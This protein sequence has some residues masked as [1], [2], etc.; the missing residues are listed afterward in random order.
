[1]ALDNKNKNINNIKE[2]NEVKDNNHYSEIN[3]MINNE[4]IDKLVKKIKNKY[5]QINEFD[6]EKIEEIIC[7]CIGDFKT[8]CTF[9][10]K[11]V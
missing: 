6:N 3:I 10:E 5:K 8:I 9:I 2:I 11:M 7:S 1:M 4:D